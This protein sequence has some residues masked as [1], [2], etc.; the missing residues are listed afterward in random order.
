MIIIK[1]ENTDPAFNLAAEEYLISHYTEPIF[2]LWRNSRSVIIGK[3]QNTVAEVDRNYCEA[4]G[5]KVMRRLTGGGAVFHDTGNVNYT[6]IEK[7]DQTKFNNYAYFT[8]IINDYLLTLG[9][10]AELS[11]RNDVLVEGKKIMGNAQCVK[12]GNILHHGCILFSADLSVLSAA[13]K[14][15]KAKIESKGIKSVSSRV[16]NIYDCLNEKITVTEFI[17]GLENFVQKMYNCKVRN[18]SR[19]EILEI[20]SLKRE[21][22]DTFEW[23]YGLSPDYTFSKTEKF[24]FGLI[25]GQFTAK[26]GKI[27]ALK[28]WG[29]F[30]G[31]L[32]IAELE[33]EIIGTAHEKGELLS[34]LNRVPL[35][36]FI[37]GC[38]ATDLIKIFF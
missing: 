22:Y 20:E 36:S 21:K 2:M 13:L 34:V 37:K 30:F 5:I 32:D 12:C 14:V 23:N 26:S 35:D 9:I 7:N 16:V 4:N 25:T 10:K 33:K 28:L 6:I 17:K 19:E 24:P 31:L 11:G 38:T 15:N 3:N 18:L 27:T 8:K 29:D 1:N